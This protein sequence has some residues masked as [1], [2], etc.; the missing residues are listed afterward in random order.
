MALSVISHVLFQPQTGVLYKTILEAGLAENFFSGKGLDSYGI[1]S[2]F[3]FAFQGVKKEKIDA[4]V[5]TINEVLT[6]LTEN[7]IP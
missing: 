4:I 6:D 5:Q 1:N 2:V 3:H 7:G